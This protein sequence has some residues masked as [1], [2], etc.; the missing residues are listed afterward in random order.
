MKKVLLLIGFLL[1][2]SLT[3]RSQINRT[4]TPLISWFDA[5]DTP[6]DLCNL[7]I[8]MDKRG[9]MFFGNETNGIVTYDGSSWDMISMNTP[10][11]VISLAT[12]TR[13][14]VYVGGE[15]DFGFLQPDLTGRLTFCSLVPK[16]SGPVPPGGITPVTSIA[17]DSNRVC[18]AGGRVLFI[19]DIRRDTVTSVDL[20][21]EYNLMNAA[22]LIII[23]RRIIIADNIAGLF[24]YAEGKITPLPG[25]GQ[26]RL[27]RFVRLL[28]Y[29][30]DNILIGTVERGLVTFN[31]KTGT[32]NSR[33]LEKGDNDRLLKTTMT[34]VVTL[35]GSMIA[36]GL[37]DGGGVYIF[38]HDGRL[39]QHISDKTTSIRES[40][41]T[42]MY[43]DYTSNS[44]LWFCT[45]G[46]INRAYV[47]L[48]ASEFGNEAG[49]ISVAGS[50]AEFRDSVYTGTDAGLYGNYVDLSGVM[51]FRKLEH[52]GSRVNALVIT[53]IP[54]G[55][56]LVSATDD[57]LWQ[58]D[59]YGDMLFIL[60]GVHL[61][62]V[63]QGQDKGGLLVTGSDDG[64]IRTL[65]YSAEVWKVRNTSRGGEV[66]GNVKTIVR[67]DTT[68][69]WIQTT[70]PFSVIRMN[71][72][73]S[74]T[75]FSIYGRERGV[76]CD[77]IT[78]MIRIDNSLYLCTGKGLF[79]YSPDDDAFVR[80]HDIIGN[81][82]D[83]ITV[84]NLIKTPE[85]D[86]FLSGFDT[87]NFNALIR[88][89]S[90]GHIVFRRQFDFLPDVPTTGMAFIKGNIWIAK[91]RS[92]FVID[93]T[94]LGFGYGAFSV[95]FTRIA[96]GRK[97]LMDG[98]FY[99]LT[100]EGHRVQSASQPETAE[101]VLN[102]TDNNITFRWTTTSYVGEENTVYRCRLDPFDKN[103][104]EWQD[105]TYSDYTNL[106]PGDYTFRLKAKTITGLDSEERTCSFSVK[107]PWYL[108]LLAVILYIAALSVILFVAISRF[109]KKIKKLNSRLDNLLTRRSEAVE[110]RDE[111]RVSLEHY[112]ATLLEALQPS[113]KTLGGV[114][115]NSFIMDKPQLG[116]SGDFR[117]MSCR[118]G[119]CTLA[120]GDCTGHG[121]SSALTILTILSLLDEKAASGESTGLSAMLSFL[122]ERLA[123]IH[124]A[125][126]KQQPGHEGT[127]IAM[128]SIDRDQM[129][130]EFAGAVLQCYKV[131][132][133]SNADVVKWKNGEQDN[134]IATFTDGKY[135]LETVTGDRM[136]LGTS[137]T[138]ARVFTSHE[139]KLERDTSY[140]IFTDGYT[141][142]F[143]GNTGKK[144]MKKNFRKLILDIQRYPMKKQKDIL[145]E[146]LGS[147]MG[148]SP[149]TDDIMIVGFRID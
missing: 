133:M 108:S 59:E 80:D 138:G 18:F 19:Y 35:P 125:S 106:P 121:V 91:G 46:L 102:H 122:H 57:G 124:D 14:I 142:Q 143:N 61:T 129:R 135:R 97:L 145:E 70:S 33:F 30:R 92:I 65:E 69:W 81:T 44:Q 48:P 101:M 20:A 149:Q 58:I 5:A 111:E 24:E 25:G 132:E 119:N 64:I 66:T 67:S 136:P 6:G 31:L 26:L 72:G 94:K 23:D 87:R 114:F 146:R 8:T 40:S 117:W 73:A 50:F 88:T 127:D 76:G 22:R 85:G 78:N 1:V 39:L 99:T 126:S 90:Q 54:D 29:D 68:D 7:S 134:D 74:D 103:W 49:I 83:N 10:Q 139:W 42:S 45:K 82:F 89:T 147:W 118:S 9:V 109:W 110:K 4:G 130:V 11:K 43:C 52:A 140:Y 56:V 100:D 98:S 104:S 27:T 120:V 2:F 93:N 96:S 3:A 63:S 123:E 128:L 86:I 84:N 71:C 21:N 60:K 32:L 113:E 95:F 144:F 141:D 137:L 105:R 148:S 17:A 28:P 36:A 75:T 115:P 62:A 15:N 107:K 12:D 131:T 16:T 112:S 13:G 47:S 77:T 55:K 116:V 37:A 38:S 41:V 53:D 79:R 34:D 51:R